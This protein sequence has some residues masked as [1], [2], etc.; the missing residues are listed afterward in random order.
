MAENRRLELT[1]TLTLYD[2]E[3][4]RE[5]L[6]I[7]DKWEI[8]IDD[9]RNKESKITSEAV[10]DFMQLGK[11]YRVTLILEE[12]PLTKDCEIGQDHDLDPTVTG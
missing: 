7:M 1:E 5:K 4:V 3:S 9:G 10:S 8:I 6:T 11:K 12:L 2:D